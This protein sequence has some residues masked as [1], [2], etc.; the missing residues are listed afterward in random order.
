MVG[1]TP[2]WVL[3]VDGGASS[4]RAAVADLDGHVVAVAAAGPSNHVRGEAGKVRLRKALEGA[5]GGALAQA[6]ASAGPASLVYLQSVTLGM[7]GVNPGTPEAER[8]VEALLPLLPEAALDQGLRSRIEVV[9]DARTALEGATEGHPGI[10]VYAG[11]GSVAMG[12]DAA[13]VIAR[14][15]GWGYLIDD[16]GG[17]YAIGRQA[18]KAVY[19]ARDGRGP[20]TRLTELLLQHF[21]AENLDA[22]IRVVYADDGLDRPAVARLARLVA[23]AAREGD[24][25]ALTIYVQAARELCGLAVAVAEALSMEG[26]SVYYSGGVFEAGRPLVEPFESAVRASLRGA[27]VAPAHHPPL[28]GALL[29]AYRQV[30]YTVSPALLARLRSQLERT[31]SEPVRS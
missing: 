27:N 23:V 2:T 5:V 10:L 11:T 30:G 26:P 17:G 8:V 31:S 18:L 12:R 9:S 24:P 7:T 19:R 16:E 15:G 28:V 22:L 25:A 4:T 21:A 14:A 1:S 20:R 13:G 3:G 29:M 6:A